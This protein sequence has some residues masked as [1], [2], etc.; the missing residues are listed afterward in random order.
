MNDIESAF[1]ASSARQRKHWLAHLQLDFANQNDRTYLAKKQHVGP[2]VLQKSL[3]PE[4]ADIC[5]GVII[6]PPGGVAGG[7]TLML[8]A[9]LAANA[10]VLLSVRETIV[11]SAVVPSPSS[12][13]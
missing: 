12:H 1:F 6:H 4:G 3:H 11:L 9:Q 2:L 7:D 5:H 8:T 10:K 13:I